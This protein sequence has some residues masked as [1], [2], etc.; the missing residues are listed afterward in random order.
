MS[1]ST[2]PIHHRS[3]SSPIHYS[4]A[5]AEPAVT[6]ATSPMDSKVLQDIFGDSDHVFLRVGTA[7]M[8]ASGTDNGGKEVETAKNRQVQK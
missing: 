3:Q 8:K 6:R 2:S 4:A 5:P 1:T 7:S